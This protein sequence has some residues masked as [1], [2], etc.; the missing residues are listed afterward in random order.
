MR[1][2][3]ARARVALAGGRKQYWPEA[4]GPGA[5]EPGADGG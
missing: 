3:S 5:D 1:I 4:D 2:S